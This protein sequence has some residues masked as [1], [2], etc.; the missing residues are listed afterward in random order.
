MNVTDSEGRTLSEGDYIVTP[1]PLESATNE[2]V[3]PRQ[4]ATGAQ[5]GQQ[6]LVN[7]DGSKIIFGMLPENNE[8]GI[9]F[10]DPQGRLVS[11]YLSATR[12]IYDSNGLNFLQDGV[13][14]GGAR[15]FIIVK[16]GNNVA[17]VISS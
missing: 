15:G 13:L 9:A 17:S 10:Y 12:Y 11:K 14:T 3:K 6:T 8:F 4:V 1:L 5:R 2:R 16:D 7:T